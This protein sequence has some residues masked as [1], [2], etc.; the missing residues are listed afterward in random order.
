M[1]SKALMKVN[2][3][4]CSLIASA[5]KLC[6]NFLLPQTIVLNTLRRKYQNISPSDSGLCFIKRMLQIFGSGL[7]SAFCFIFSWSCLLLWKKIQQYIWRHFQNTKHTSGKLHISSHLHLHQKRSIFFGSFRCIFAQR[8]EVISHSC[9]S[10][11]D[12][13]TPRLD[14]V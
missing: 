10:S 2:K 12:K 4:L 5:G 1:F 8:K 14:H 3:G 7:Q 13:R 11:V 9:V 6:V